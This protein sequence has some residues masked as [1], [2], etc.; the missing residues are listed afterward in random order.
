MS[1]LMLHLD[2]ER[3]VPGSEVPLSRTTCEFIVQ[4]MLFCCSDREST[5]L[6]NV[7]KDILELRWEGKPIPGADM[8]PCIITGA[9]LKAKGNY[10]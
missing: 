3:V 6:S 1:C 9:Y 7:R 2:Q 4:Y 10:K 8:H 5:A